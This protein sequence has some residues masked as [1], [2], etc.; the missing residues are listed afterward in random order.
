MSSI[1]DFI[2]RHLLYVVIAVVCMFAVSFIPGLPAVFVI[3][4][5]LPL[6]VG[7]VIVLSGITLYSYTPLNFTSIP[8]V[9]YYGNGKD[10]M[11]IVAAHITG[12]YNVINGIFRTIGLIVA[13]MFLAMYFLIP[14]IK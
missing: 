5:Q 9:E 8:A 4:L 10:N 11:V 14:N 3:I 1:F 13:I 12:K 2:K 7:V 6:I